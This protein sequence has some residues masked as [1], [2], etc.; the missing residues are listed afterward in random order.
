MRKLWGISKKECPNFLK[1]GTAK[2]ALLQK[3][4]TKNQAILS[5]KCPQIPY[6]PELAF[7]RG[8]RYNAV[9]IEPF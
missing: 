2:P 7:Q 8:E 9:L 1:E 3:I 6:Q 5:Q 4:G